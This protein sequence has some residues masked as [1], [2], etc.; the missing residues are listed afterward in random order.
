MERIR[1]I[2]A[3]FNYFL[4]HKEESL[5]SL[6]RDLR[7]FILENFPDTHEL[8]YHTHAL[9]SV[10]SVS[11]KLG[12]AYCMIPIYSAHLNLGFNKGTLI[13]DPSGFLQGTG[14]LIRH[15]PVATHHDYRKPEVIQ[16]IRDA[17]KLAMEDND[18]DDPIRSDKLTHSRIKV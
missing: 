17:Y 9:T 2:H 1:P 12:D 10:Y 15:I 16:L 14:K 5:S 4:K 13:P 6:Y 18:H 8:L 7:S 11:P 3:D